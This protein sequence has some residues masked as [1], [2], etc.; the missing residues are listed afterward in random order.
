MKLEA[1]LH[2]HT[3]A[4]GHAF[5]TITE[6]ARAAKRKGIKAI[7]V[8]DHGPAL[9]G[10]AHE[11]YFSNLVA[12]PDFIDGVRIIKGV[13]ANI[14]GKNGELD[15]SDFTLELL[16]FVGVSFH[17][18]CG[19][20]PTTRIENTEVLLKAIE[21][22]NV[23]MVCHPS[24]PGFDVDLKVIV[25]KCKEKGVLIEVNNFS[26]NENSFRYPSLEENLKLLEICAEKGAMIALNSDAH[27]H[28]LVGE[29]GTAVS[30]IKKM[31][32]PEELIIN[33]SYKLVNSFIYSYF[34]GGENKD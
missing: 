8:L 31:N 29:V 12:L 33:R 2:V 10:G 17:P 6:I 25:E 21:N 24:V 27:F 4:S 3:I 18:V 11:Y 28:E 20:E 16:E 23:K 5:S 34:E 7:A 1:D 15:I 13:E 26:F 19:Y 32:F 30:Y 9:P 14:I 22:T